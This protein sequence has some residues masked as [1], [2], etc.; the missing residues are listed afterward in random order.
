M[1]DVCCRSCR[2]GPKHHK[3]STKNHMGNE[4]TKKDLAD[5]EKK[6]NA[7]LQALVD[8]TNKA[9]A[10]LYKDI[11][12]LVKQVNELGKWAKAELDK[13]VAAINELQKKCD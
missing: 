10:V 13:L 6:M 11:A 2:I 3:P 12:D 8:S 5:L 4:A 7:K 1:L 9:D